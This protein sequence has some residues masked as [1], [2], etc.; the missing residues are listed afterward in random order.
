MKNSLH[1]DQKNCWKLESLLPNIHYQGLPF[2]LYKNQIQLFK[3][4]Y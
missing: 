4:C 1:R 2:F 3:Q